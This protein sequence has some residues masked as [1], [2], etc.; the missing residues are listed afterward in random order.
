MSS[1]SCV[2]CPTECET[3]TSEYYCSS[4]KAGYFEELD[5]GS[6]KTGKCKPCSTARHC[7]E[8]RGT[9]SQCTVCEDGYEFL[10]IICVLEWRVAF[11]LE[12]EME[13]NDFRS[14]VNAFKTRFME[15]ID[16]PEYTDPDL[17]HI[18]SLTSG[19][20]KINAQLEVLSTSASDIYA[21][22]LAMTDSNAIHEDFSM[23]ALE[24]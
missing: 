3:C 22:I 13:L 5:D 14:Q 21:K 2:T 11:D 15:A 9:A 23:T 24:N 20:T 7:K 6:I 8:C 18:L 19:S 12:L 10:G 1:G 17:F 16:N 4:C